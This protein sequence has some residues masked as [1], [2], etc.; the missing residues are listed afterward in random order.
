MPPSWAD[1]K[2]VHR[3]TV[4]SAVV[5][6]RGDLLD[7]VDRLEDELLLAEAEDA[8]LNRQPQAPAIA[9]RILALE[10]QARESECRFTFEGLG[11]GAYAKLS[12]AH[13]A[14]DQQRADMPDVTLEW[15]PETFPPALLAASCVEPAEL[16]GNVEEWT[17][18]HEN[19]SVGQVNRVW[20][21]CSI[22]NAGVAE[23]PNSQLASVAQRRR[24]SASSS[25]TPPAGESPTAFS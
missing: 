3:N 22:A 2:K 19:Y 13:P 10:A 18:I 1:R 17:E 24:S 20:A 9:D 8:R 12:A 5:P 6:L 23:S 25:T 11:R 4:R 7:E 15:N 21:A 14:T 16:A